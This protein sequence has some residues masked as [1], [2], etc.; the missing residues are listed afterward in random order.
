MK[1]LNDTRR[2]KMIPVLAAVTLSITACGGQSDTAPTT[3]DNI[4]DNIER[5]PDRA[6]RVVG[7]SEVPDNRYPWMAALLRRDENNASEG[8]FCGGSLI[9]S[10]W[11]LTA[12]HC[13]Q[14]EQG[15][16][17]LRA[18][19]VSVLIGRQNLSKNGGEII[20]V[21]RIIEHPSYRANGYPD[22]A[23]VEL[24][25]QSNAQAIQIPSRNNPVPNVGETATVT[26]WGQISENGPATNELRQS[27]MPVV[28][29]NQCNRAYNG[30]IVEDAMVCAGTADGSQDS[31]YGDSGGP[32]FVARGESYVQAGVVSFGEACG[33]PG[34]PG[35]YAR[36]SSYYDWITGYASVSSSANSI[37]QVNGPANGQSNSPATPTATTASPT[38]AISCDALEC[39]FSANTAGA[40]EFYWDFGDGYIDDGQSVS[41]QYDQAGTY[42]VTLGLITESGDYTETSKQVTVIAATAGTAITGSAG[43]SNNSYQHS[44]RLNG[45]GDQIDLPVDRETISLAGGTLYATLS[46]EDNHRAVL[47][48]DQYDPRTD[49]WTEVARVR[50]RGGDAQLELPIAAGQYGFTVMSRGG[51]GRYDLSVEVE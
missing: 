15:N 6:P 28:A 48:V 45:R 23:L 27:V 12:A 20:N 14:N 39:T 38:I 35:V 1:L 49:E 7:G 11:I 33:L 8:Q 41:Y 10:R 16:T 29:H 2:Q 47:F 31:C 34:V 5:I 46:L 17:D 44:G 9:A 22:L 40:T 51:A 50:S 4:V 13:F 43:S 30:E 36:V 42:T 18:A 21:S 25:A 24:A 26:G 37:A 3:L 19:D 32:L